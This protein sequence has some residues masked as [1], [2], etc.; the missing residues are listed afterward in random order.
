MEGKWTTNRAAN[1][2]WMAKPII[3]NTAYKDLGDTTLLCTLYTLFKISTN[4]G[5]EKPKVT[6]TKGINAC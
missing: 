2:F 1:P 5:A 4:S 3:F 6:K